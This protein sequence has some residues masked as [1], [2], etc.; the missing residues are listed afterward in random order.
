MPGGALVANWAT[1][2]PSIKSRAMSVPSSEET[3]PLLWE[4]IAGAATFS[5][6]VATIPGSDVIDSRQRCRFLRTAPTGLTIQHS[7]H[8]LFTT[9]QTLPAFPASIGTAEGLGACRPEE[10]CVGSTTE[11]LRLVAKL[12]LS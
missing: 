12:I 5:R 8:V 2:I 7:F 11:G 9:G 4:E 1:Q 10:T 3:A 6:F